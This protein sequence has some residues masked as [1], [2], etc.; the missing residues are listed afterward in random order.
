LRN[1]GVL[2]VGLGLRGQVGDHPFD[3]DAELLNQFWLVGPS[4]QADRFVPSRVCSS[5]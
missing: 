1:G 3:F 2:A 4:R 5:G